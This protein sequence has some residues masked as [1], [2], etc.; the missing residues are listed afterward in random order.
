MVLDAIPFLFVCIMT[1]LMQDNFEVVPSDDCLQR[2]GLFS[3]ATIVLVA[4]PLQPSLFI[5]S[6][7][8]ISRD[9]FFLKGLLY[10]YSI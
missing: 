10:L 5:F 3:R 7:T 8:Q 1:F 6:K 9:A 4:C 2:C